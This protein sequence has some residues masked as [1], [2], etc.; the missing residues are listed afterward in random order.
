MDVL[1]DKQQTVWPW[2][3]VSVEVCDEMTVDSSLLSSRTVAI[4]ARELTTDE[5]NFAD[6]A[7]S[8]SVTPSWQCT[9]HVLTSK[10]LTKTF[11][12]MV[13]YGI[14]ESNVPLDTL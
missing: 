13:W 11:L 8:N 9:Y 1:L 6:D 3:L 2:S 10:Q 12:N 7:A 5:D 4:C 14:V